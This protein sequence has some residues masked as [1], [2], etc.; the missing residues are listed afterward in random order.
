[1]AVV[2]DLYQEWGGDF[3]LTAGGDL[4]MAS[5][6]DLTRQAIERFILT[7]PQVTQFNGD[8]VPAD[9]LFEPTFGLGARLKVGQLY[10]NQTIDEIKQILYQGILASPNVDQS[11][12]PI[13]SFRNPTPETLLFTAVVFLLN[14]QQHTIQ[15]SLP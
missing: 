12:P 4:Q 15:L 11:Q 2:S 10:N 14:G 9:D 8:P 1:M 5:D 6:W 13:I 7:S 3:L